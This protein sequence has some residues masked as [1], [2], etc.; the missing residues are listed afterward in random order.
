ML[1]SLHEVLGLLDGDRAGHRLQAQG[2]PSLFSMALESRQLPPPPFRPSTSSS[3]MR[4]RLLMP[5]L[6]V[7]TLQPCISFL[8]FIYLYPALLQKDLRPL[9]K[10]QTTE[11]NKF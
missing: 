11:Q 4:A 10:L 3:E 8:C 2:Q 7:L 6:A 5:S 9:V 1:V